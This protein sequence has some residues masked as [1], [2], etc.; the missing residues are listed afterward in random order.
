MLGLYAR[1]AAGFLQ[2][3]PVRDLGPD[4]AVALHLAG[5]DSAHLAAARL[6]GWIALTEDLGRPAAVPLRAASLAEARLAALPLARLRP[7]VIARGVARGRIHLYERQERLA[8]LTP[9]AA[10]REPGVALVGPSSGALMAKALNP[11]NARDLRVLAGQLANQLQPLDYLAA[12]PALEQALQRLD[13]NWPALSPREAEKAWTAAAKVL[14]PRK[15]PL[16]GALHEMLPTYRQKIRVLLEDVAGAT[17]AALQATYL[18]RIGSSLEQ[19]DVRAVQRIAHQQGWWVRDEW[20]QRSDRLT[21][22]G[23]DIVRRGLAQGLGRD[24]IGRDLRQQLPGMWQK[25]G[26]S[27]ARLNAGMA[28][29]RARSYSEIASYQDAGIESYEIVSVIDERTTDI[30]RAL[31]GQ[32]ISVGRASA[33]LDAQMQLAQP[34]DIRTVAPLCREVHR[35]S[36]Y[37]IETANGEKVAE[38]VR[39]GYGV[40]DDRGTNSYSRMGDQLADASI[41]MPPYHF[42]CRTTTVPR[43]QMPTIPAGKVAVTDP[44]PTAE[45]FTPAPGGTPLRAVNLL[46]APRPGLPTVAG[47]PSALDQALLPEAFGGAGVSG[48]QFKDQGA[49]AVRR[50]A[51][52]PD[53]IALDPRYNGKYDIVGAP[54]IDIAKAVD[55][56]INAPGLF[57]ADNAPQLLDISAALQQGM[58]A[59]KAKANAV[60]AA[61]R[62]DLGTRELLVNVKFADSAGERYFLRAKGSQIPKDAKNDFLAA[63]KTGDGYEIGKA[64]DRFI[65]RGQ[66]EGWAR[67][68]YD[69]QDVAPDVYARV[70]AW[71]PEV[72]VVRRLKPFKTKQPKPTGEQ[73]PPIPPP[74]PS[75]VRPLRAG[76]PQLRP[77][78][79]EVWTAQPPEDQRLR[80][81]WYGRVGNVSTV[82]V[83]PKTGEAVGRSAW[84]EAPAKAGV[85]EARID[86]ARLRLDATDH[87]VNIQLGNRRLQGALNGDKSGVREM[88]AD[89]VEGEFKRGFF[90]VRE[91]VV[92]DVRGVA[93]FFR[94]NGKAFAQMGEYDSRR[95]FNSLV[96]NQ[97]L[98][99]STPTGKLL[100]LKDADEIAAYLRTTGNTWETDVRKFYPKAEIDWSRPGLIPGVPIEEQVAARVAATRDEINAMISYRKQRWLQENPGAGLPYEVEH[101]IISDTVHELARATSANTRVSESV[102]WGSG[103][104]PNLPAAESAARAQGQ[105]LPDEKAG[106]T[107]MPRAEQEALF[108]DSLY[109]A[110]PKLLN[111][112][113]TRPAPNIINM[114]ARERSFERDWSGEMGEQ[115]MS[116]ALA[117][118]PKHGN[119]F[120]A[121]AK[122]PPGWRV[123]ERGLDA[124]V[125]DGVQTA[126]HEMNHWLDNFGLNGL[127]ARLQ[128]NASVR[129]GA[130]KVVTDPKTG[131]QEFFL[132]GNTA[133]FYD[134]K[135][136]GED[137]KALKDAGLLQGHFKA[138]QYQR[139]LAKANMEYG[140]GTEFMSQAA[141]RFGN[142]TSDPWD[143][144]SAWADNPDQ[145]AGFVARMRG[146]FVP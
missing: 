91:Y 135:V 28:M 13:V 50:W 87:V 74:P 8:V 88:W 41:G 146:H 108:A 29:S 144:A 131:Q 86:F 56:V 58:L 33:L 26:Q 97:P 126:R 128:R 138:Q 30:C 143:M 39:S 27:Y 142:E 78:K 113:R 89:I 105:L 17:K 63:L 31:D 2:A 11:R 12:R 71:T 57:S 123:D 23:R 44:G 116:A 121:T 124:E 101:R 102:Q 3:F 10:A 93:H 38:V 36:Q 120:P 80:S 32:I 62:E 73:L 115:G 114:P 19:R 60:G 85:A 53:R 107:L 109:Y 68:G 106:A 134:M 18:P 67:A 137:L 42:D 14:D 92:T 72:A 112:L 47:S 95:Y 96:A 6:R 140:T 130:I 46:D 69:L 37:L 66:A 35:G 1:P 61:I 139:A 22:D 45:T 76:S 16:A 77:V 49:F 99:I 132:P 83:N 40:R 43:V 81:V 84:V 90:G 7:V 117:L 104:R 59:G 64:A 79:P 25:Y 5:V 122:P 15:G 127:A 24:E 125:V 119:A 9:G 4:R 48:E 21:R 103:A 145:V 70:S 133:C 54:Q 141:S 51:G 82:A 129:D 118:Y 98:N 52:A 110:S 111:H 100:D 55:E 75:D 34:E 94:Y 20:G 136:Y 65:R